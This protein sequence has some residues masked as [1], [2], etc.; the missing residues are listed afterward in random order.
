MEETILPRI[1]RDWSFEWPDLL[2]W[3]HARD[4]KG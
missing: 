2:L 1:E 3:H 4:L